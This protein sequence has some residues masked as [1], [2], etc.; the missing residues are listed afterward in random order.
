MAVF[1]KFLSLKGYKVGHI[2]CYCED[3][4]KVA[5]HNWFR[6]IFPISSDVFIFS[7]KK[8]R[9]NT[10]YSTQISDVKVL[11]QLVS[12]ALWY[13]TIKNERTFLI[14][15]LKSNLIYRKV[16]S[17]VDIDCETDY[18]QIGMLFVFEIFIVW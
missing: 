17:P 9:G 7:Q 8:L 18:G 15:V 5:W 14:V 11:T 12:S 10:Q 13:D 16:F 6:K 1:R 2:L 3:N 4:C